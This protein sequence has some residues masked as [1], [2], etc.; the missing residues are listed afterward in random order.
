MA[1]GSKDEDEPKGRIDEVIGEM[2]VKDGD[3]ASVVAAINS[4]IEVEKWV[5][6]LT[7]AKVEALK[8]VCVC[9][10]EI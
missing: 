3:A 10:C 4:S 8:M 1:R 5:S 7:W 2:N 9:V 6:G